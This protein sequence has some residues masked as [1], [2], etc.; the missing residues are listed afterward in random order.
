MYMCRL[1][2]W[3]SGNLVNVD[4]ILESSHLFIFCSSSSNCYFT[5]G[6]DFFDEGYGELVNI[7]VSSHEL[8]F[9]TPLNVK[10]TTYCEAKQWHQA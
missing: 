7:N 8:I 9:Q 4:C 5:S 3:I 2:Q 1:P 6:D 10:A